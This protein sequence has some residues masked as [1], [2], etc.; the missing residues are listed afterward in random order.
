MLENTGK[1]LSEA[2]NIFIITAPSGTGKTT[3]INS[4]R[5]KV[6]GIGYSVSHTTRKPREGEAHGRHYYFVDAK[7]FQKMIKKQEFLEWA[8]VYDQYYGTSVASVNRELSSEKDLLMDLDM[9]GAK[10]VKKRF[11]DSLQVFILPP[12]VQALEERLRKRSKDG[13]TNI[14]LRMQRA[15]GEIQQCGD[16]DFIVINDNLDKAV[17]EVEAIIISHRASKEKR[18]PL[19]KKLFHL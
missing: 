2:G 5:K 14:A 18:L 17:N 11:P 13:E 16:Y 8:F 7:E 12:S 1:K 3:I 10:A 6:G 4:V 15:I 9:Q 19:V